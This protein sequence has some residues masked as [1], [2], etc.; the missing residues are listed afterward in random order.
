MFALKDS[1]KC[2]IPLEEREACSQGD[3]GSGD[4]IEHAGCGISG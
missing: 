2:W 3:G 1:L 4:D